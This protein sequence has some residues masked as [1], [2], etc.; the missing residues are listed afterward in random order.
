MLI[1]LLGSGPCTHMV[2]RNCPGCYYPALH[3]KA[4]KLRGGAWPGA[5]LGWAWSACLPGW[6]VPP[7][8]GLGLSH[9]VVT[10]LCDLEQVT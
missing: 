8:E 4:A 9:S 6:L 2:S 1:C 10:C 3:M 5:E 7:P